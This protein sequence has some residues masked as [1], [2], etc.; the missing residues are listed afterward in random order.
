MHVK[1]KPSAIAKQASMNRTTISVS[2][3]R[4]NTS[5][6]V[7]TTATSVSFDIVHPTVHTFRIAEPF[8]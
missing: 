1:I 3:L 4:D 5:I 6:A 7:R 8:N 2:D